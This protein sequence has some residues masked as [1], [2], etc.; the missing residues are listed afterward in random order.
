MTAERG[1]RCEDHIVADLTVVADMAAVHEITAITDPGYA[2]A[3]DG[4]GV[5]GD[6][7]PDGTAVA[8]LEP[9]QLAAIA[10]RLRRR[11]Q[12]NERIDR[13]AV[14]D[15]GLRGDV[16]MR[17]QLAVR[18]DHDVGTDDAV[19]TDRGALADHSAILNPRSGI[20]RRHQKSSIR[21]VRRALMCWVFRWLARHADAVQ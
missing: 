2:T 1:R 21:L 3:G 7:L 20:D 18:A 16:H 6:L 11:A 15:R 10:Q 9:G 13:A 14:A 4:A 19:R 8:D 5:H 12:R 17:D